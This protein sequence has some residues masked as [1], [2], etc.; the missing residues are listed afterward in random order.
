MH[1]Y[2]H[3]HDNTYK[4]NIL[5]Y[6][7]LTNTTYVN[8]FAC[9]SVYTIMYIY[10]L[11]MEPCHVDGLGSVVKVPEG[12]GAA[13]VGGKELATTRV[14]TGREKIS[15]VVFFEGTENGLRLPSE[16]IP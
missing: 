2:I 1:T 3:P 13:L 8:Q 9:V 16:G 10:T 14:P 6:S 5:F 12:N 4:Y 15:E 7:L 11:T